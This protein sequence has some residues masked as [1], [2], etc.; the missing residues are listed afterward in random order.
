MT[1]AQ[2]R[3]LILMGDRAMEWWIDSMGIQEEKSIKLNDGL[4]EDC[5]GWLLACSTR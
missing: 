2:T 4:D 5:Q 1:V 3:V